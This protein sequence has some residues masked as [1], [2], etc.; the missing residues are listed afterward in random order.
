MS[1]Y[2]ID[3]FKDY[4]HEGD[5]EA[6]GPAYRPAVA[7]GKVSLTSRIPGA[8]PVTASG[9]SRY[10]VKLEGAGRP[11]TDSASE[12]SDWTNVAFR[13]DLHPAPDGS[14]LSAPIQRKQDSETK[15][16]ISLD[17]PSGGGK[18]LPEDVRVQMETAL[19]A[20]FSAVRI[21]EGAEAESLGALAYSQGTD[22]HF[23]PGLYDP[24]GQRGR[25]LL[26]H[27]LTHVVQQSHGR[28]RANT[29]AKG[30]AINDNAELE[31]EADELGARAARGES[32]RSSGDSRGAGAARQH[33]ALRLPSGEAAIQRQSKPATQ[34]GG[35]AAKIAKV[36]ADTKSKGRVFDVLRAKGPT[37]DPAVKKEIQKIFDKRPDDLWLAETIAKEGPEPLWS[38]DLIAERHRRQVQNNW[39][40]EAGN[41]GA[42]IAIT[43]QRRQVKAFFFPGK[44]DKRALII[45][46]VHGNE[47]GGME[48]V[49]ILLDNLRSAKSKP[50]YTVIVIPVLFPDSAAQGVREFSTETNR[51]FPAP[52]TSLDKSKDKSGIPRDT[53]PGKKKILPENV[54][55]IHLIE[56]FRPSRICS[57]HGA[58]SRSMAGVFSD[59]HTVSKN[60]RKRVESAH[61]G[62]K[63]TAKEKLGELDQA[64]RE[65]GLADEQ[66][67]IRMARG[68]EKAGEGDAVK[69][70]K[71]ASKKP[72]AMWSGSVKKG[73]SLGG[74]GPQDIS[75]GGPA[76]RPSMT[77]ITVEVPTNKRS[78][79]MGSAKEQAARRKELM[80][81]SDVIRDIFLGPK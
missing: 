57:V 12:L 46:G 70:N 55:L 79:E 68:I 18:E 73:T 34:D 62:D 11:Q 31:R 16:D 69:G 26:G 59:P 67:A 7:P 40:P 53:S 20:D 39:S 37:K 52:G 72:T 45:G 38:N 23:Q 54:A 17:A 28:V 61:K 3:D 19:G 56:R 71:L 8:A 22:I 21:H 44:T 48:V 33:T 80:A 25:E 76:D 30:A 41:I 9:S 10:P 66:M 1:D 51:N 78:D 47:K 4:V 75:E 32:A 58:R 77:V 36:W 35:L 74:W 43:K 81:F 63:G 64:A 60:A 5:L 14:A 29:Q 27:E 2:F 15:G 13:P 50:H 65:R 24:R 42:N 6:S 49:E